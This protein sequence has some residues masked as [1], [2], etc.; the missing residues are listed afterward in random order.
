MSDRFEREAD[1]MDHEEMGDAFA[2]IDY[3]GIIRRRWLVMLLVLAAAITAGVMYAVRQ[4]PEYEA[5]AK[6]VL[7]PDFLRPLGSQVEALESDPAYF[8]HR[9]EIRHTQ[10]TAI[11]SRP[12]L[13]VVADKLHLASDLEFLGIASLP[14]DELDAARANIDAVETLVARLNVEEERDSMIAEIRVRDPSPARAALLA[15]AVTDAYID[16]RRAAKLAVASYAVGW[17]NDQ[18]VSLR[19]SLDDAEA[20]MQA[21]QKEN[22]IQATSFD[23][24]QELVRQRHLKLSEELLQA[25]RVQWHTESQLRTLNSVQAGDGKLLDSPLVERDTT[26]Q[27]LGKLIRELDQSVTSLSVRYGPKHP[28]VLEASSQLKRGRESL[29]SELD[30]IYQRARRRKEEADRVAGRVQAALNDVRKEAEGLSEI[31]I[32]H[33]RLDYEIQ[34]YRELYALVLKRSK[35]TQITGIADFT[36]VEILQRALPPKAPVSPNKP[37]IVLVAALLGLLVGFLSAFVLERIDNRLAGPAEAERL[38]G[39]PHLGNVLAV[40]KREFEERV[41]SLTDERRDEFNSLDERQ[42]VEFF[43]LFFGKSSLAESIRL[44]RTNLFF[45]MADREF[46]TILVTSPH[47]KEG[48][49]T[50]VNYLGNAVAATGKR[51]VIVDSDLHKPMLHKIHGLS[52]HIGVTNVIMRDTA[53]EEAVRETRI[54]GLHVMTSGPLPPNSAELLGSHAFEAMVENLREIYDFVILDSPPILALSD[55][56]VLS[57][58]VH[59]IVLV[60]QPAITTRPALR[61][62]ARHLHDI[63]AD[64]S[65]FVMNRIE[66]GGQGSYYGYSR[67]GYS[68]YGYG[69][70]YERSYSY[71]EDGED[72]AEA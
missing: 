54:P 10:V 70:S 26:I 42:R 69:R 60:V 39:S 21:F 36:D 4:A 53:V 59:G 23:A 58:V 38:V 40:G 41:S 31:G 71:G 55:A 45:M 48:K 61:A 72:H 63:R 7:K 32:Q 12:V 20:K 51:V 1:H 8:W 56:L 33:Q 57:R 65:G 14:P 24:H 2:A 64:V 3:A 34:N 6:I 43:P 30:T 15:N 22:T 27:D 29:K 11:S 68:R 17:L 9:Q 35:E 13:K 18:L 66:P 16:H 44:V 46:D 62:T 5:T 37:I 28:K 19:E 49:S 52:N 50:I 67:Y 25:K 47:P